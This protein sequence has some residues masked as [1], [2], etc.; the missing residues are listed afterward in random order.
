V[1]SVIEAAPTAVAARTADLIA[2]TA[3]LEE[4]VRVGRDE[5]W[6]AFDLA[7]IGMAMVEVDEQGHGHLIPGQRDDA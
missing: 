7:P 5:L 1:V 4:Q 3:E 6:L 2:V